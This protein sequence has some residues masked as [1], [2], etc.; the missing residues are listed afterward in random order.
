MRSS[1]KLARPQTIKETKLKKKKIN[2]ITHMY[3]HPLQN[4]LVINE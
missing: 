3:D 1:L 4:M 2:V